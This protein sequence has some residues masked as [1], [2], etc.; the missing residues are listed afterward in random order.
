M[1]QPIRILHILHSMNRGGA[2]N[3]LMN[4]YRHID[5]SRIQ[6]D[7]LLTEKNICHFENEICSLGGKVYRI[8]FLKISNPFP[9]LRGLI[10]FFKKH[11]EYNIVHS[12]TSS[13][14]FIPLLVAKLYH[15]PIRL[16]HSHNTQSEGGGT[17]IIRNC[18]MP[19]L[20]IVATDWLSCGVNAGIWLYG[21]AAVKLGKVTVFRNVIEA[22]KFRFNIETRR[23]IR[24]RLGINDD[25]FLI[26]HTARFNYQKNHMFDI[27]L[28][29][30]LKKMYPSVK[31]IEIGLGVE[32]GLAEIAKEKGV[33]DDFIFT[34]VVS[35]VYEYEQAM[36]VFILPSFYEGLPL[37]IIEAQ[38]SGLPC[39]TT[40]GTVSKEC[41]V[42]NL[43]TY[44]PLENGAKFWAK[45]I[46]E[47]KNNVREDRY[48]E[49]VKA[50]YNASNSARELQQFYLNKI[51]NIKK[52]YN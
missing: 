50:G 37:S 16:S 42:T 48:D 41:S 35:N 11:T 39:Y 24:K 2:E 34:G 21:E 38:V 49:I 14:S 12:H 40:K 51:A 18:L 9:Y 20:K 33:Y 44:I 45:K 6:F 47:S 32:E 4:Y 25:V 26:G 30:E 46:I 13:K 17:G 5:R 7:F 3:A 19:L 36:D 8:P 1:D 43:V 31:I 10:A 29:I 23:R 22:D 27:E 28:I 15:I 52:F